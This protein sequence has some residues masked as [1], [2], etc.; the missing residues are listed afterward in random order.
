MISKEGKSSAMYQAVCEVLQTSLSDFYLVRVFESTPCKTMGFSDVR[1]TRRSE[2]PVG[3]WVPR[4]L[5]IC[6][7]EGLSDVAEHGVEKT[8]KS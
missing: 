4:P 8:S 2:I 3:F 6:K 5:F 1:L 7:T